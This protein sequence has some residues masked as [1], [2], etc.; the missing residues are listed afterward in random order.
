MIDHPSS[1]PSPS[2]VCSESPVPEDLHDDSLRAGSQSQDSSP[3]KQATPTKHKPARK[4]PPPPLKI[5]NSNHAVVDEKISSLRDDDASEKKPGN[6]LNVNGSNGSKIPGLVGTKT[7]KIPRPK[8][9]PPPPPVKLPDQ[10]GDKEDSSE[11]ENIDVSS[12]PVKPK[13]KPPVPPVRFIKPKLVSVPRAEV[14]LPNANDNTTDGDVKLRAPPPLKPVTPK[15]GPI[16]AKL[17][18]PKSLE[19]QSLSDEDDTYFQITPQR[20]LDPIPRQESCESNPPVESP[21]YRTMASFGTSF[22][23]PVQR[24]E[25]IH[26]KDTTVDDRNVFVENTPYRSVSSFG[27]SFS[28][29][30]GNEKKQSMDERVSLKP[31]DSDSEMIFEN[32]SNEAMEGGISNANDISH[33]SKGD[34]EI[35]HE[36]VSPIT[37]GDVKE[38]PKP[39]SGIPLTPKMK[40]S[41]L[42]SP[43]HGLSMQ[44]PSL[45]TH[46]EQDRPNQNTD[47]MPQIVNDSVTEH[48]E[49]DK[50]ESE[51]AMPVS[52]KKETSNDLAIQDLP[53]VGPELSHDLSE[54]RPR[55]GSFGRPPVAPKP[56]KGKGLVKPKVYSK[57]LESVETPEKGTIDHT[58]EPVQASLVD[59]KDAKLDDSAAVVRN[60]TDS[61]GESKLPVRPRTNSQTESRIPLGGAMVQKSPHLRGRKTGIPSP[62]GVRNPSSDR[63]PE[64][65]DSKQENS[66]ESVNN[67]NEAKDE[68]M[69]PESSPNE[70]RS[71]RNRS[72]SPAARTGIPKSMRH[73]SNSPAGK[74]GIPAPGSGL[75]SPKQR[76]SGL[77]PPKKIDLSLEKHE[78]VVAPDSSQT[79]KANGDED[80]HTNGDSNGS[81]EASPS[82]PDRPSKPPRIQKQGSQ[83]GKP[84]KSKSL[85]PVVHKNMEAS[86]QNGSASPSMSAKPK[87]GIPVPKSKKYQLPRSDNR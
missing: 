71:L 44:S 10:T 52:P 55:A 64:V 46:T 40:I 53:S 43:K 33:M 24:K 20:R 9:P 18:A 63:K 1:S 31:K 26:E 11:K 80:I 70:G 32:N 15:L 42:Q 45:K 61:E 8:M 34:V 36:E 59:D 2:T 23:R 58:V 84:P 5:I 75:K 22:G 72:N 65:S 3:I 35:K 57:G 37:A 25:T 69:K 16:R 6:S 38:K 30:T 68:S 87:R 47:E 73:R 78:S 56:N 4:A 28:T 50:Q 85:L 79:G 49:I 82:R 27:N 19:D 48:E 86:A 60:R 41:K 74:S 76:P 83:D 77:Q 51:S 13:S 81:A 29:P 67:I 12:S 14:K 39:K 21:P 54:D 7:P 17:S 62:G 66:K